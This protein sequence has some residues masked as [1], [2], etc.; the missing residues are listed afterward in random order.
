MTCG[1]GFMLYFF[2]RKLSNYFFGV[3]LR[4]LMSEGKKE[5]YLRKDFDNLKLYLRIESVIY[6][7][8]VEW[9][10]RKH[11]GLVPKGLGVQLPPRAPKNKR[12]F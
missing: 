6:A 4:G 2:G 11:E 5:F 7:R 10:T 8:V 9:Q 12:D 1:P 3:F